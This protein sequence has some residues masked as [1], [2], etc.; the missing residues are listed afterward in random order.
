MSSQ[1]NIIKSN[2]SN[3]ISANN[4][5]QE[6]NEHDNDPTRRIYSKRR[7]SIEGIPIDENNH[8]G[9]N[10][11]NSQLLNDDFMNK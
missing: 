1:N 11:Y 6:I 8:G 9:D 10:F 3:A 2:D 7:S 4:D 5:N